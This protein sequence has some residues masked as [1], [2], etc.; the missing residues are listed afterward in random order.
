MATLRERHSHMDSKKQKV[1]HCEVGFDNHGSIGIHLTKSIH[2]LLQAGG[3]VTRLHLHLPI[4]D[5]MH[6]T[7]LDL[8]PFSLPAV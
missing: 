7:N 8:F 3:D 4:Q 1:Y 5:R 6:F 2:P